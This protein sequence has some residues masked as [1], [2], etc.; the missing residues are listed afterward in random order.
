MKNKKKKIFHCPFCSNKYLEKPCL[1]SHMEKYHKEQLNG[2][3][4]SQTYFNMKYK[5]TCGKCIM[6]GKPTKWCETTERY[7]RLCSEECKKKYRKMFRER[8]KK[9]GK[10]PDHFLDDPEQQKKML[11][12]RKIS[13]KYTWS[14]G[15]KKVYVG[16]YERDF[17]EFCD[18]F[19]KFNSTDVMSPAPQVIPYTYKGKKHSHIPDMYITSLNLLIQVKSSENK[20]YR[21]RD[22]DKEYAIDNAIKKTNFNYV[23]VFDKEYEE[24]FDFIVNFNN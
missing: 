4:P 14:D 2:L 8:M 15:T 6:C 22:I 16:T 9:K 18:K 1:Y 10:D 7:E 17:L 21:L 19:M 24:F 11:A 5:K 13:G 23:K 12:N 3:S 20:H